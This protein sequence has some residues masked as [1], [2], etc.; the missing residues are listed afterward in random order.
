MLAV[1]VDPAT[2]PLKSTEAVAELPDA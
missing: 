2:K 1:V